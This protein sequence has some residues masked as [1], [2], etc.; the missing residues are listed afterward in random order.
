MP[1]LG[2]KIRGVF[3]AGI[4]RVLLHQASNVAKDA[5]SLAKTE[6]IKRSISVPPVMDDGNRLVAVVKV[7]ASKETGAPEAPAYEFGSGIW[8]KEG[9]KYPI[10]PVEASALAFDW[11]N[12]ASIAQREGVSKVNFGPGG[13]VV[14]PGV[15]HPGVRAEPFLQPAV[16]KNKHTLVSRL[17]DVSVKL[18]ADSLV[19]TKVVII[20]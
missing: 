15:M 20:K 3:R 9:Q 11:P 19:E 14:L 7:D 16:D 4:T 5:R 13:R 6:R 2:S 1:T 10:K 17:A 8:G 18:L 12:A